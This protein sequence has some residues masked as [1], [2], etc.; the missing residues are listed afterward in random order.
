MGKSFILD[1]S[2]L[3]SNNFHAK[4]NKTYSLSEK[5]EEK[6]TPTETENLQET[7]GLT[8]AKLVTLSTKA[9]NKIL[10]SKK[11]SNLQMREIKKHR[12][13]LKNRGYAANDRVKRETEQDFYISQINQM[14]SKIKEQELKTKAIHKSTRQLKNRYLALKT[15]LETEIFVEEKVELQNVD[16]TIINYVQRVYTD[17]KIEKAD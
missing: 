3:V 4:I 12:R 17:L 2:I 11:L 10:K 15:R 5:Y 13:K 7:L 8:D 14:T 16:E 9:L 1:N 6:M